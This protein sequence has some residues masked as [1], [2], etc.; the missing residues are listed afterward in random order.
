ME[1]NGQTGPVGPA[2][3]RKATI[4]PPFDPTASLAWEIGLALKAFL[5]D[6]E[7]SLEELHDVCG[8]LLQ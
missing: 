5:R 4:D 7:I 2:D 3:G 8:Y 1:G 6:V